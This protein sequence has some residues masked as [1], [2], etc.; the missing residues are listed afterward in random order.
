[1]GVQVIENLSKLKG[2]DGPRS[3]AD[4]G[5]EI[6]SQFLVK[7][8]EAVPDGVLRTETIGIEVVQLKKG[9]APRTHARNESLWRVHIHPYLNAFCPYA[10]EFNGSTWEHYKVYKRAENPNV[11][12]FGHW[13]FFV[14]M[15]SLLYQKG[16][17]RERIKFAFNEAKEDFRK[18]GQVISDEHLSLVLKHSTSV[19]RDRIL[20][21][22]YTGMRPGEVSNLKKDRVDLEQGLIS[23]KKQ[24]TKTRVAR[25]FLVRSPIVMEILRRRAQSPDTEFFFPGRDDTSKAIDG[26]LK[27]WQRAIYRANAELVGAG[28]LPMPSDYTPHDL[29]H[30]F[31][32]H[33]FRKP[34]AQ[35]AV[36]CFM[37]GLT[38][39]EAEKTYLHFTPED[40]REIAEELAKES[41][42]LGI[43]Q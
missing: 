35:V 19:W 42:A 32:T 18:A 37:C 13:K 33:A 30:T 22:R 24:D 10:K 20:I 21:Q 34:G 12:L 1:V 5:R 38:L 23:L 4:A 41:L 8:S 6:L 7:K 15:G 11:T 3:A 2:V 25:A 14:S 31:L 36:T 29:R 26:S 28:K 43:A 16:H 17:K 9:K 27:Y 40:T 39:K